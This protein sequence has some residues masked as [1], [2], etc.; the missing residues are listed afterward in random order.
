M[1]VYSHVIA[2]YILPLF[3]SERTMAAF[4]RTQVQ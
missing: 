3:G 2:E 1:Y 4:A